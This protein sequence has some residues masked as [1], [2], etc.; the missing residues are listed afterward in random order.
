MNSVRRSESV[1]RVVSSAEPTPPTN[2][3]PRRK[4]WCM[5]NVKPLLGFIL[6]LL[7]SLWFTWLNQNA[8]RFG[9][10]GDDALYFVSGKSLLDGGGYRILS[11]PGEP[12]QTKYPPGYPALLAAA[13]TDGAT[14]PSNLNRAVWLQWRMLPVMLLLMM[15]Y[16]K[17]IGLG[18]RWQ[19]GLAALH[20]INPYILFLSVMLMSEI[21]FTALVLAA[22]VALHVSESKGLKWVAIAGVMAGIAFL[23]R[24]IGVAMLV[25]TPLV[26]LLRRKYTH[27][28][29]FALTMSPAVLAWS[30]WMKLHL[31][32][33]TGIITLYYTNYT[34][35]HWMNF[36]W[37]EAHLF[38]WRNVD[39]L[40]FGIGT[41]ILPHVMESGFLKILSQVLAL[42]ALIGCWRIAKERP[43]TWHYFGFAV[44]FMAMLL[45]WSFP[46]NE[47]F[48]IPLAPLLLAGFVREVQ[49]LIANIRKGFTHKDVSQRSAARIMAG[50]VGALMVGCLTLQAITTF[51]ILPEMMDSF[52]KQQLKNQPGY[53]W[54]RQNLPADARVL[55]EKD[56]SFYLYTGRK[57]AS[58]IVPTIHLYRDDSKAQIAAYSDAVG[59]AKRHG[60]NYIY[61]TRDDF[62]RDLNPEDFEKIQENLRV[63]TGAEKLYDT[64]GIRVFRV[65]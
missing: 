7:P 38:L 8:P 44:L 57:A 46:P 49:G 24:T 61:L 45:V 53:E 29:V 11:L 31:P 64:N 40:L 17:R 50:V 5:P 51:K 65:E 13:W 3:I 32:A 42:G 43:A 22:L 20:G 62:R 23:F 56:T 48:V 36:H 16:W 9:D 25:T 60:L 63:L 37:N 6:T 33:G 35:Y 26:F 1:L 21:P 39:S 28:A 10:F 15:L 18:P 34:G 27:A 4:T 58:L 19:W 2:Q 41:L 12:P 30:L 59:Y 52:G 55:A 14:F 47:R 54:A